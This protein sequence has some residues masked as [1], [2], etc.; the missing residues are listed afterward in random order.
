MIRCLERWVR[1]ELDWHAGPDGTLCYVLDDEWRDRMH[2]V[3]EH[4]RDELADYAVEY[5]LR[6]TRWLLYRHYVG[7][8]TK[9]LE[10]PSAWPA[11][12][13]GEAGRRQYRRET[14]KW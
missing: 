14:Q 12:Q 5:C 1:P 11:W 3:S 13:H 6:N 4:L 10:W 2:K 9:I 8:L 7:F